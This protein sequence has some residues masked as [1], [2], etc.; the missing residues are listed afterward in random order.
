[1]R[2]ASSSTNDVTRAIATLL[3]AVALVV[4]FDSQR[5]LLAQGKPEGRLVA[6]GDIHGSIEG[7]RD[8]LK[9]AGIAA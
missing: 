2:P 5:P 7:I 1:M 6:V 9:K 3:V 4:P 8:V